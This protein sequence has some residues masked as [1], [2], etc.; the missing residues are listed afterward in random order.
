MIGVGGIGAT[1]TQIAAAAVYPQFIPETDFDQNVPQAG[2][3]VGGK[4][5]GYS[6]YQRRLT[7]FDGV[8]TTRGG[9]LVSG[10]GNLYTDGTR[11]YSVATPMNKCVIVHGAVTNGPYRVGETVT[12]ATSNATGWVVSDDGTNMVVAVKYAS[13]AFSQASNY[14]LTGATSGATSATTTVNTTTGKTFLMVADTPTSDFYAILELYA[15]GMYAQGFV[16]CGMVD[17]GG[18]TKHTLLFFVH[19]PGYYPAVVALFPD[20]D[21]P[22]APQ[23]LFQTSAPSTGGS[24]THVITHWHGAKFLTNVG[25]VSGNNLLVAY[26]GDGIDSAGIYLCN[27]VADFILHPATWATRWGMDKVGTE[28]ST[29]LNAADYAYAIGTCRRYATS[30]L[31]WSPALKPLAMVPN[32]DNSKAYYIAD[33]PGAGTYTQCVEVNFLT[34]SARV[35]Q[36]NLIGIG[37]GGIRTSNGY[38]LLFMGSEYAANNVPYS[39]SD[40][41]NRI[42]AVAPDGSGIKEIY[43]WL[44]KDVADGVT[45]STGAIY[46]GKAVEWPETSTD[47]VSRLFINSPSDTYGPRIVTGRVVPPN[48]NLASTRR[49]APTPA[50]YPMINLVQN[51]TADRTTFSATMPSGPSWKQVAHWNVNA[52]VSAGTIL[53]Y[54]LEK[55][56]DVVDSARNGTCSFKM[57]PT[58]TSGDCYAKQTMNQ[59]TLDMVKGQW[60][61]I[62]GRIKLPSGGGTG[63]AFFYDGITQWMSGAANYDMTSSEWQSFSQEF[64][65]SPTATVGDLRLYARVGGTATNPVYFSDVSIVL[66]CFIDRVPPKIPGITQL[67][68]ISDGVQH[69]FADL[70]KSWVGASLLE[71]PSRASVVRITG[72]GATTAIFT[73]FPGARWLL[74]NNTDSTI[75]CTPGTATVAAGANIKLWTDGTTLYAE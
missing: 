29:L 74:I 70:H 14:T 15:S 49:F 63:C 54:G 69:G 32:A 52:S 6:V 20:D 9:L 75:T 71:I 3:V 57:T 33:Y 64:F 24:G 65:V 27:D 62:S 21:G 4:L 2:C 68:D 17:Y 38:M 56:T 72:A 36:G 39:F 26:S 23:V 61:T 31:V 22:N 19:L 18:T 42:Y 46:V 30:E 47:G 5:I 55:S 48:M 59:Q 11:V 8:T 35:V 37:G 73:P 60:I 67:L 53:V 25:G 66:G 40:G 16:D 43:Q 7:I 34:R 13:A 45:P 58:S 1:E 10:N 51:G 44:R 41:Y 28:R 12:Q 50:Q